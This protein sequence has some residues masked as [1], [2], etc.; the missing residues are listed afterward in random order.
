MEVGQLTHPH[1]VAG[2]EE[3]ASS[4][5]PDREGEIAEQMVDAILSP[6]E[7]GA[8][9]QL[10]VPNDACRIYL[11][12]LL[13]E[14]VP[15]IEARICR[16]R[17]AA[18]RLAE[19]Q[20]LHRGFRSGSKRGMTK[21]YVIA[22][23][24]VRPVRTS[25]LQRLQQRLNITMARLCPVKADDAA[26]ATHICCPGR[27]RTSS[28]NRLAYRMGSARDAI[29]GYLARMNSAVGND[30][31]QRYCHLRCRPGT[32]KTSCSARP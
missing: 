27:S 30:R 26:N 25:P 17:A 2:A 19:R 6:F 13:N 32:A 28:T 31:A 24:D 9:D 23:P 7:I 16:D 22:N 18:L 20:L 29:S 15:T 11:A 1:R 10:P 3:S 8:K 5:I 4:D 21:R 14:V 12:E